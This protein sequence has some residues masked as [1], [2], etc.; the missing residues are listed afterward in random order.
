MN[1]LETAYLAKAREIGADAGAL[2]AIATYFS[3]MSAR[4]RWV[5]RARQ[6]AEPVHLR[7]LK[8]FA[9]RAYRRPL[10]PEEHD[11]LLGFY[12]KLRDQDGLSHEDAIRDSVASVLLSP[13]FCYR[14]DRVEVGAAMRPLSEYALA[15]RL[16][17]FL[18]SSMPDET[19]LARAAAGDL[20][21]TEVLT[22]QVR[23]ML[24]DGR[25]RGLATEFA[26]NW[27]AFRRFDEHNSVD[28]ERFS[29]FTNE[30]RHAM[31]EEP[32]HFFV[33]LVGRQSTIDG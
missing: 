5:E 16:S 30:L 28:R 17:Y 1:Q 29:T 6:E 24:R 32:I 7:A 3:E 2:E 9:T 20:H 12:H 21:Q 19:L 10:S 25:V 18:W 15:S 31:Y 4:I 23:R 14:F 13:N 26:G 11:E 8:T 22:A 27:L 33:D